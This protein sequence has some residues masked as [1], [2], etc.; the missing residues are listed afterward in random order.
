[1][2]RDS[3]QLGPLEMDILGILQGTGPSSVHDISDKLSVKGKNLAYTTV[4]TVLGRLFEKGLLTREKQGRQFIYAPAKKA[5][6]ARK[7]VW[8]TVYQS[9]FQNDRLKPIMSLIDETD[10]LTADE[11]AEL[12]KFVDEKL[13]GAGRSK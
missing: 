1:M 4:M 6:K 7:G 12:K 5:D 10:S 13:K 2:G 11:L 8:S 3:L 9:L